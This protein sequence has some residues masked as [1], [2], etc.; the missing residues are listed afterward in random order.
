MS[1]LQDGLAGP[2]KNASLMLMG[3]VVLVLL[4]ACTNIANLLMARTADRAA[5]YRCAPRWEQ[6]MPG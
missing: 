6:A 4:I 1:S 3:A 5:E 2:F